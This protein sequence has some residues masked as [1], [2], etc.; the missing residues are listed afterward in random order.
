ME[1]Q[2]E[3]KPEKMA[4]K[5]QIGTFILGLFLGALVAMII[6]DSRWRNIK[7]ETQIEE[8]GNLWIEQRVRISPPRKGYNTLGIYFM[9]ETPS[10]N[11]NMIESM[12]NLNG[13]KNQRDTILRGY[14]GEII[15]IEQARIAMFFN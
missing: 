3:N 5:I 14:D 12:L 9:N 4:E 13:I 15:E 1:A 2:S 6:T 10:K 7:T 11:I 8:D